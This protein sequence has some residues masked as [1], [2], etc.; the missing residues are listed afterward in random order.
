MPVANSSRQQIFLNLIKIFIFVLLAFGAAFGTFYLEKQYAE[1]EVLEGEQIFLGLNIEAQENILPNYGIIR[2]DPEG[3]VNANLLSADDV[4][5]NYVFELEKGR[6]WGNFEISDALVNIKVGQTVLIPNHAQFDLEFDGSKIL[7]SVYEG[8]VYLGFL[9]N[10]MEYKQYMDQYSTIFMNRFL[11]PKDT[12]VTIP[13]SKVDERLKQLLF[14]KMVK[15]FKYSAIPDAELEE[16]WYTTNSKADEKIIESLRQEF[17]S[18]VV[19]NG[20]IIGSDPWDNLVISLEENLTFVPKKKKERLFN[21]VFAYLD[22][23]IF[24]YNQGDQELAEINYTVFDF[25]VDSSPADIVKSEEFYF[26][27]DQKLDQLL[28]FGPGEAYHSLYSKMLNR[29]LREKRDVFE[30]VNILWLDVYKSIDVDSTLTED[31]METFYSIFDKSLLEITDL[32][33][34]RN[35]LIFYNQLFENLFMRYPIFYKDKYFAYKLVL[36]NELLESYDQGQLKDELTQSFVANKISFIKRLKV[37]FFDGDIS[38]EQAKYLLERLIKETEDYLED[39]RSEAAVVEFFESELEDIGDFWGYLD[40]PEYYSSS[41]YGLT[42]RERYATYLTETEQYLSIL[43]VQND[44]NG[45]DEVTEIDLMDIEREIEA[46]FKIDDNISDLT[47]GEI[48][49]INQ[50]YVDVQGDAGGYDFELIYDRST[51]KIKEIYAEDVLISDRAVNINTLLPLLD[52]MFGDFI[53]EVVGDEELTEETN[54]QRIARVFIFNKI[55]DAGFVVTLESVAIVDEESSIYRVSEIK[56]ENY[57]DLLFSFDYDATTDKATNLYIVIKGKP[58]I[59]ND[60]YTLEEVMEVAIL[61]NDRAILEESGEY[62]AEIEEAV[63][64]T[65]EEEAE[66]DEESR[67]TR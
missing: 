27:Y 38:V 13:I 31:T 67:V 40:D 10:D 15:E 4:D 47:F 53:D 60:E 43:D 35:Y 57:R 45:D 20:E 29:K 12:K 37:F 22:N 42:H 6:L 36:E 51:G 25:L 62:E 55:E 46:A 18:S 21:K 59:L 66:E 2:F 34:K 24:Y 30:I 17:T 32:E 11:V 5:N 49:D 23:T 63:S 64:V 44:L 52:R 39:D 50:R 26:N 14:S 8:D 56:I 65:E 9:E 28:M 3:E 16:D 58:V 33:F 19:Y 61:E 54:A 41:I 1:G 7:L 48:D